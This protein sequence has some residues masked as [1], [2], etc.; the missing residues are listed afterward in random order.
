MKTYRDVVVETVDQ[1]EGF[2][3]VYIAQAVRDV[4]A[5]RGDTDPGD[6]SYGPGVLLWDL[7]EEVRGALIREAMAEDLSLEVVIN[8]VLI[9]DYTNPQAA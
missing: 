7:P 5:H 8:R 3:E 1:V 2:D 9:S 4:E 6:V